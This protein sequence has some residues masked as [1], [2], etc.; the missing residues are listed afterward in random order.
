MQ[1]GK[2]TLTTISGGTF[3]IDGG[4]MFGVV[5]KLLWSKYFPCDEKN[6]IAQ[7][8]NCVLVQD[9]ER[10]IL[11]DTGYGSKFTEKQR[12]I[13]ES[14]EG[15][16]LV[17]NLRKAGLAVEDIDTVVLSHL[18]FDHAGGATQLREDGSLVPTF[19]NAEYVAQRLEWVTATAGFPELK[20]AYPQ[21]NL[22][23][24]KESGQL[25]LVD[26]N[27]EF[28]PGI[29]G[30]ITGGHTKGHTALVIESGG[31]GAVY[32]G[33]ICPTTRHLPT[34]WGMAYDVDCLEVRR[35]RP[36]LLGMIV[37]NGWWALFDHDPD[38]AAAKLVRDSRRD[39][40]ITEE[41]GSL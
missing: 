10:N 7:E 35:N 27:V 2:F 4:T 33:D 31:E 21:E 37:E 13:F 15:D 26:G 36:E 17:E 11:I 18:H 14:E 8:T 28:V 25:R 40:A 16:P 32:L 20:T 19:P 5:P 1:L 3:R 9:G 39:F 22:L 41:L 24:L 30:I 34:L 23:P 12:K 38:H 6:N 29:R